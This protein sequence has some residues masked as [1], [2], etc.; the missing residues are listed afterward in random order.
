M[1]SASH[2]KRPVCDSHNLSLFPHAPDMGL[3]SLS[4]VPEPR[5]AA[6]PS[7]VPMRRLPETRRRVAEGSAEAGGASAPAAGADVRV[8][9]EVMMMTG[10]VI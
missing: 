7:A 9:A 5:D 4:F 2:I 10:V 6:E 3:S 1:N 8:V